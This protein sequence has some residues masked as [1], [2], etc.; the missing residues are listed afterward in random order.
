MLSN[1]CLKFD[2]SKAKNKN[3][4]TVSRTKYKTAYSQN[5]VFL[6]EIVFP[7]K[8]FY[9]S[10]VNECASI[11][12][13]DCEQICKNT[14]GSYKCQCRR[15][16]LLAANGRSCIGNTKLLINFRFNFCCFQKVN[17]QTKTKT[18]KNKKN[19]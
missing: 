18:K 12:H 19:K 11:D 1:G 14:K 7:I 15:G 3:W 9:V 10:D 6:C 16:F 17:K 2:S 8:H 13:N 5:D 4:L